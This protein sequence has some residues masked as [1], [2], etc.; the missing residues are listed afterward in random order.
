VRQTLPVT[1]A[2]G[3]LTDAW[4]YIYNWPVEALARIESGRFL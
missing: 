2:D 1:L 4:T 3:S